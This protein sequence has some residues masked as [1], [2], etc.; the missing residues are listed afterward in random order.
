MRQIPD[1]VRRVTVEN[2]N[3]LVPSALTQIIEMVKRYVSDD[4]TGRVAVIADTSILTL[5]RQPLWKAIRE[6]LGE[7]EEQRL[8]NQDD[9]DDQIDLIDPH[10]SKGLEY[11]AVVMIEPGLIEENGASRL[12]AAADLYVAMTRPTQQLVI[13]RTRSDAEQVNL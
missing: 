9:W 3:D 11:D 7:Q 12:S 1:S 10:G 2:S 13:V 5:L 4:G 6:Q 8:R